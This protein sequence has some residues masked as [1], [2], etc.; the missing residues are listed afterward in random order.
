MC[1]DVPW[2]DVWT[3]TQWLLRRSEETGQPASA[4]APKL[5]PQ[6]DGHDNV[7]ELIPRIAALL[8][9][10]EVP[11]PSPMSRAKDDP[12]ITGPSLWG[13]RV[14]YMPT[15]QRWKRGDYLACQ[16]NGRSGSD[17]KN[18]PEEADLQRLMQ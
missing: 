9:S 14:T 1:Q 12:P 4:V 18:P 2:A 6:P 17:A 7:L 8:D 3:L 13:P 11:S 15:R 16:W 5:G 10:T